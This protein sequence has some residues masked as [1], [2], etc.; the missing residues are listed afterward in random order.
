M[1]KGL[2]I[3]FVIL[4]FLNIMSFTSIYCMDLYDENK[5]KKFNVLSIL[6]IIF[7]GISWFILLAVLT[8]LQL[9][10]IKVL[11][12]EC[13]YIIPQLIYYFVKNK[14]QED[15]IMNFLKEKVVVVMGLITPIIIISMS[16]KPLIDTLL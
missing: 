1:N 5:L 8:L 13:I 4:C 9:S 15:L 3:A 14:G 10:P 6:T 16:V 7:A 12:M 2:I 11:A